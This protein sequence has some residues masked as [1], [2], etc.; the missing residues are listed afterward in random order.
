VLVHDE[1][2]QRLLRLLRVEG[3]DDEAP[4]DVCGLLH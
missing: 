3:D 2:F 4:H 1:T